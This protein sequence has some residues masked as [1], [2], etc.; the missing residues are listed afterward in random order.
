MRNYTSGIA[1]IETEG[2]VTFKLTY[3]PFNLRGSGGTN[4]WTKFNNKSVFNL[5]GNGEPE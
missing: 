3:V 2:S 1:R 4:P 5:S